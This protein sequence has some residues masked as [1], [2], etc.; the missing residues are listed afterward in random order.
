MIKTWARSRICIGSLRPSAPSTQSQYFMME[1]GRK[2]RSR[3]DRRLGE[4]AWHCWF[5]VT[6]AA[7]LLPNSDRLYQSA[8]R[9]AEAHA[10]LAPALKIIRYCRALV[11]EEKA[12]GCHLA[13]GACA[14]M[15]ST[16]RH[17]HRCRRRLAFDIVCC[18][19][20]ALNLSTDRV[21]CL[22]PRRGRPRPNGRPTE[23]KIIRWID[24]HDQRAVF[25]RQRCRSI[26]LML[27]SQPPASREADG[28]TRCRP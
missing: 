26:H 9:R 15:A 28:T 2:V 17:L 21:R 1:A 23:S 8:G 5:A 19:R 13:A 6:T 25:L 3:R 4:A 20:F 22:L 12:L 18:Q 27:K 16:A 24:A 11:I 14:R 7:C 10:P